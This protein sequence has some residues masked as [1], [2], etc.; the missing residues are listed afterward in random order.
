MGPSVPAPEAPI[1]R[2]AVRSVGQV[3]RRRGARRYRDA[4]EVAA[5][6]VTVS[7][8]PRPSGRDRSVRRRSPPVPPRRQVLPRLPCSSCSPTPRDTAPR[9]PPA[10]AARRLHP[11]V[12]R[13]DVPMGRRQ[14]PQYGTPQY[15]T[16]QYGAPQYGTPVWH[17]PVRLALAAGRA[18][19]VRHRLPSSAVLASPGKAHRRLPDRRGHPSSSRSAC[20]GSCSSC[21]P[22]HRRAPPSTS[23]GSP[24]T[25]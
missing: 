22:P 10:A 19:P 17:S 4:D 18:V 24:P 11:A 23:T 5:D 8:L 6:Q 1:T 20:A 21:W 9:R 2:D 13:S 3:R 12:T 25:R 7:N 14:P 16:P 15:G